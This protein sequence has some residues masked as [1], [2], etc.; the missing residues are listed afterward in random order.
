MIR[1]ILNYVGISGK[2]GDTFANPM[3]SL[4]KGKEEVG[5][6]IRKAGVSAGGGERE[7]KAQH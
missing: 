1:Y 4:E 3:G 2:Q 5:E 7:N 6:E